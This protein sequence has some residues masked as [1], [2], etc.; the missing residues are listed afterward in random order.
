MGNSASAMEQASA[1]NEG[2]RTQ[3]MECLMEGCLDISEGCYERFKRIQKLMKHPPPEPMDIKRRYLTLRQLFHGT[4][5]EGLVSETRER[6]K[7]RVPEEFG[8]DMDELFETQDKHFEAWK[9]REAEREAGRAAEE[10]YH[11]Q[12]RIL[13]E[14]YL[15]RKRKQQEEAKASQQEEKR[16]REMRRLNTHDIRKF[17]G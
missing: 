3:L 12:K 11:R 9:S 8:V 5:L 4:P 13:R 10:E 2:D 16:R 1:V 7:G 6:V 17:F 15:S 14:E